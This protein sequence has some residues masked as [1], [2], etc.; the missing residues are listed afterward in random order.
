MEEEGGWEGWEGASEAVD[1][2]GW[3][4][5]CGVGAWSSVSESS[6]SSSQPMF[7]FV[8]SVAPGVL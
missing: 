7:S 6:E 3:D 8:V 4:D 2:A 1:G 5:C